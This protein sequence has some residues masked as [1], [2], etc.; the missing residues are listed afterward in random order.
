MGAMGV[1]DG[2]AVRRTGIFQRVINHEE[3][4]FLIKYISVVRDGKK[5]TKKTMVA[6]RFNR[7]THFVCQSTSRAIRADSNDFEV[8]VVRLNFS[9][10]SF[11]K[12]EFI[13]YLFK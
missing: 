8:L 5:E 13:I 9:R 12:S 7:H 6:Q 11:I 3:G 10:R 2:G 1:Q 4:E